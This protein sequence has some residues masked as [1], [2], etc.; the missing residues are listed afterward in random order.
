MDM[1]SPLKWY[2]MTQSFTA[3]CFYLANN[4]SSSTI[5]KNFDYIAFLKVAKLD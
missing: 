1:D 2:K 5:N 3:V 4:S